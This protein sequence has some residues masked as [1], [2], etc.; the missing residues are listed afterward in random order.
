MKKKDKILKNI[1]ESQVIKREKPKLIE[2]NTIDLEA[3][4]ILPEIIDSNKNH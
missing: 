2:L 1:D 4:K 3:L